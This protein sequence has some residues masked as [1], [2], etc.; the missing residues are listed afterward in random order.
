MSTSNDLKRSDPPLQDP[1]IASTLR[2]RIMGFRNTQLIAVVAKLNVAEYLI[3]G[4]KSAQQLS[5]L[6]TVNERSLYRLLRALSSLGI[7][8]EKEKE[9]FVN[10]T[11]SELLLE[12]TPGSLRSVAILYGEEWIWHAYGEL[13][14]S[15]ENGAPAFERVHGIPLYKYLQHTRDAATVFNKAMTAYS[16]IEADAIVKGYDFSQAKTVVDV[17]GGEGSLLS[18]L[19]NAN[20]D[21]SGV[22][23]DLPAVKK[24]ELDPSDDDLRIK[25]VYGDF[26]EGV[27]KDGD[28]YILKSVLHNW[29]DASCITI[30]RNCRAVMKGNSRLLIIE[31]IVSSGNE[32]SEAKLFDINMM[33]VTGGQERTVE[34]YRRLFNESGFTLTKTVNTNSAV[35]ILEGVVGA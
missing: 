10:T 14:Y 18:A 2:E 34:E 29:D 6:L 16:G 1:A 17:G 20:P 19:V 5:K 7:F 33:V 9:T 24:G 26:F 13:L 30:L 12:S 21:L 4:P 11:A 22:V 35:S 31:R 15:I 32:K 8:E 28:V 27:P 3:S 25:Y 23:F